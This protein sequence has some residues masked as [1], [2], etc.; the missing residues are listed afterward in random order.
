MKR[1]VLWGLLSAGVLANAACIKDEAPPADGGTDPAAC[2]VAVGAGSATQALRSAAAAGEPA[3]DGR[4]QLLVRFKPGS[5]ADAQTLE[6]MGGK[7]R[8][9]FAKVRLHAVRVTP[10]QR[11]ALAKDPRVQSIAPDHK[12]YALG[13]GSAPPLSLLAATPTRVGSPGEETLALK[14]VQAPAV[15][16]SNGDGVLDDGAP[17]GQGIRVCI[18]DSGMDLRHPELS[19]NFV[20]GRDFVDKA[21][22]GGV[23]TDPSDRTGDFFGGGHGTHVAG[24]IAAQFANG[25]K[26]NPK[27]PTLDPNGVIGVAPGVDLLIARA[28][29]IDGSGSASDV[30]EA[31]EWCK[32]QGARIVTM[33]LGSPSAA[34]G[35]NALFQDA[36]EAGVLSIA[37]TGNSGVE[38]PLGF[39]AA[40]S[41]VMAVGAV[42][43][44]AG[45]ASF[46]QHFPS[47]P[48]GGTGKA[49][50]LVAPG[51]GIQSTIIL[52]RGTSYTEEFTVGGQSFE[53]SGLEFSP[54]SGYDGR[55]LNC[56]LGDSR[57]SCGAEATCDG[58]VAYMDRGGG[59]TF[60]DKARNA[61]AQGA[62]A[63]VFGNNNAGDDAELAFTLGEENPQWVPSL[64]VTTTDAARIKAAF[65]SAVTLRLAG[66]DYAVQQGTSMATPHVSAVAALV[67]SAHPDFTPTEVRRALQNSA[68]DLGPPGYDKSYGFGLVQAK[69]ALDEAANI[70]ASTPAAA[71][72]R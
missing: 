31:L 11:D 40:H 25:A 8:R 6:R 36:L 45:I 69:A 44:D 18:I 48:D 58:F 72:P 19:A 46:S 54:L 16:D 5:G 37:A 1:R 4:E 55:L 13:F 39:P 29:G 52:G 56:G 21:A 67:W 68:L 23:D 10:E 42:L 38:D 62:R 57:T 12:V 51:T 66:S 71:N 26:V 27:D 41:S 49:G 28:L 2:P 53:G 59:I 47:P 64:A 70:A 20:G 15:W 9:S 14:M 65:G 17:T 3:D 63:I 30:L 22:D 50:S 7:V 34:D 24:T 61:I 35:E 43:P 32:D 60:G 33:S